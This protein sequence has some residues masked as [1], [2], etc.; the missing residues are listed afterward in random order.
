MKPVKN[1]QV[2]EKK[3]KPRFVLTDSQI[4]DA[5]PR[6]RAMIECVREYGIIDDEIIDALKQ[7]ASKRVLKD[8]T[9]FKF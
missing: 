4:S 5:K 3:D 1:E 9:L 6:F 7:N 8:S 2:K